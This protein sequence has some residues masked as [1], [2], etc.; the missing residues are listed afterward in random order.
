M[1]IIN[2]FQKINKFYFINYFSFYRGMN[3]NQDSHVGADSTEHQ[4]PSSSNLPLIE[5]LVVDYC[6]SNLHE[7]FLS[8]YYAI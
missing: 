6:P 8:M 4:I 1:I 5:A 7:I 2:I 3:D